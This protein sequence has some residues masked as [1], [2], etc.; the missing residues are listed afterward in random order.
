MIR[1]ARLD[2]GPAVL[3]TKG[4][5][6]RRAHSASYTRAPA[7]YD[8]GTRVFLFDSK[9][10]GHTEVKQYLLAMQH[11]K[12][13]FCESKIDH[14]S[15][16]DVE[17]FRPKAAVKQEPGGSL[18]RPGYYWLAY[19][20]SNLLLSCQL[21][22]QRHKGNLFPLADPAARARS[23]RADL[24]RE[25]AIFINPVDDDPE[26]L[27]AFRAEVMYGLDPG[28]RGDAT[29]D[30]LDLNRPALLERRRDRYELLRSL[31]EVIAIANARPSD[32]ELAV[33]ANRAR[34]NLEQNAAGSAEYAGM[35]RAAL[36]S[37]F[38][39]TS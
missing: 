37:G 14:I 16:G 26:I 18:T 3:Q 15:Y 4:K 30:A 6:K 22:N 29:R 8:D 27:L 39:V 20:W 28:G 23:H 31:F 33:L 38:E 25:S 10:Y 21:C 35:I 24:S 19:E 9:V 36:K 2:P 7:G 5:A 11:G 13:A 34:S 12:C 17:H 1:I 32:T